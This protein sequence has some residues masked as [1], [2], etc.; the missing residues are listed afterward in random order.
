MGFGANVA[1]NWLTLFHNAGIYGLAT[2][3]GPLFDP[4]AGTQNQ[5]VNIATL[6]GL[7]TISALT[8]GATFQA[9]VVPE[10]QSWALMAAGLLAV[11]ALARRRRV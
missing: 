9:T 2:N 4:N 3:F 1:A 10:P 11:G 5:F 6:G 8:N 7:L